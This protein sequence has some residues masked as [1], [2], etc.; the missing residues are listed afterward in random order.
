MPVRGSI[1]WVYVA[2][3]VAAAV[4]A[5]AYFRTKQESIPVAASGGD[6]RPV[7][8]TFFGLTVLNFNRVKP[9]LHFGTS[10]S[11][12]AGPGLAWAEMNPARGT[13]EFARLDEFIAFSAAHGAEPI[14]TFGRT[15]RWASAQPNNPIAPYGPGQCAPPL[16]LE[17]WDAYVSAVATHA[18][19]RIHYW[20]LWNEPNEDSYCGDVAT[21][22][23]M[24]Q[25]ARGILRKIDPSALLLT[26]SVDKATGPQWLGK[27]L[28]AGGPQAVDV[29]AFHGY[30]SDRP[31]DIVPV[32]AG[33]R[34]VTS[35]YGAAQFPLWDTEASWA[36]TSKMKMPSSEKQAAFVARS[37]LLHWSVGVSR[38]VWY[39]YDGNS[40]WGTLYTPA[41]G[42]GA[43]AFAYREVRRWMLGA[44]LTT[45]CTRRDDG[46][47]TCSFTRAGGYAAQ[48]M[49]MEHGAKKAAVGKQYTS[50]LDL[51]GTSHSVARGEVLIGEQPVL[52]QTALLPS[53]E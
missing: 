25:R 6:G 34:D 31:E 42:E 43:A 32:V 36:Y 33:V 1:R 27:F 28:S 22:V 3:F 38:Y 50:Y 16:K 52:L 20:E 46:M 45:P 24:A 29:V 35:A 40:P 5:F 2:A 18:A 19:G 11:W 49:W 23:S 48:A 9:S 39:A 17:D 8:G 13:Y 26:P 7:P 44:S 30:W 51:Q 15:P 14:Y 37:F 53:A 4:L 47:W 41:N 12:D 21:L 10:R